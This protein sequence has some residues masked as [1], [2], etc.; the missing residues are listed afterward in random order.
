[1]EG[2][3]SPMRSKVRGRSRGPFSFCWE[4]GTAAEAP[5][6]RERAG[7]AELLSGLGTGPATATAP[8]EE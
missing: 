5:G 8:L 1:M 3:L 2:L 7:L 6:A 4:S